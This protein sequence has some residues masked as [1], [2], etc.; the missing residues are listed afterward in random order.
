MLAG[1]M[2]SKPRF[3]IPSTIIRG[4]LS[5]SVLTPRIL[6]K[7]ASFP[8]SPVRETTTNPGNLP[9]NELE[10]LGAGDFRISF[11]LTSATEPVRLSFSA[12]HNLQNYLLQ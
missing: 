9:T 8:G 5:P 2:R 12:Y 10:T 3:W 6:N 11:P 4:E 7:E 1:S